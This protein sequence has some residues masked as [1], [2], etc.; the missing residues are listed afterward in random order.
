MR[1]ADKDSRKLKDD[2]SRFIPTTRYNTK[3]RDSP[4]I[5]TLWSSYRLQVLRNNHRT[6]ARPFRPRL[7]SITELDEEHAACC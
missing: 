1:A 5:T 2:T 6:R 4:A 7:D 3:R